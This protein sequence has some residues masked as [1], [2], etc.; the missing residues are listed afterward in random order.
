ME[1]IINYKD[2]DGILKNVAIAVCILELLIVIL[3][4]AYQQDVVKRTETPITQEMA[5]TFIQHP[6]KL[7][8]NERVALNSYGSLVNQQTYL[9]VKEAEEVIPFPWKAWILISVGAPIGIAFLV[10][11]LTRAYFQTVNPGERESAEST[12]KFVA[13]LNRL[14]QINIIWFMLLS[15]IVLFFFWYIPEVVK[16]T[17]GMAITWLT[18][19]WWI[20][21]I[22]LSVVVFVVFFWIYLQYK[23]RLRAMN[24]EMELAKFKF[25]QMEG[26][27]QL[28]LGGN[29]APAAPLPEETRATED[30]ADQPKETDKSIHEPDDVPG[31]WYG[32]WIGISLRDKGKG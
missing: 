4:M 19:Y 18:R 16:Y 32:D 31:A 26:N 13:A 21:A 8:P 10:M 11:L 15:I 17:G 12:G 23:L 24:M 3:T 22:V 29:N 1:R 30:Q 20:P 28:L 6:E 7:K 25:L 5:Q 9:L 27:N 2:R 14:S